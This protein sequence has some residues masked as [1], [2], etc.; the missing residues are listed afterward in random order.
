M[1][2]PPSSLPPQQSQQPPST[3]LPPSSSTP[4]PA[5]SETTVVP[6]TEPDVADAALDSSIEQDAEIMA[7]NS[8]NNTAGAGATNPAAA[9]EGD[10]G[11]PVQATSVDAAATSKKE[12]SLREFL[13]K[14]DEYAPIV[15]HHI[16]YMLHFY[17]GNILITFI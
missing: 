9:G 2:E 8:A 12:T 5:S 16:S 3:Q 15:C 11:N 4:Q 6:K 7:N 14:M 17:T 13:G 1:S 10:I